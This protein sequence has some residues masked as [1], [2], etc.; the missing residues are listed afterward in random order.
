M[1][2]QASRKKTGGRDV[3]T[4]RQGSRGGRNA[5]QASRS[6]IGLDDEP[7]HPAP[8]P[9]VHG[10]N[11]GAGHSGGQ[12]VPGRLFSIPKDE[13]G[14]LF[15]IP[16]EEPGRLFN[17]PKEEPADAI[18]PIATHAASGRNVH[19]PR[20]DAGG[21][22]EPI[23]P[24]KFFNIPKEEDVEMAVLIAGPERARS[25]SVAPRLFGI[26][27]EVDSDVGTDEKVPVESAL[28][29]VRRG[30]SLFGI[31]TE[32][33]IPDMDPLVAKMLAT[34]LASRAGSSVARSES[35][36]ER[37]PAKVD[38]RAHS[39]KLFNIP[40][41]IADETATDD[42]EGSLPP[43]PPSRGT[44]EP[45]DAQK[46]QA[47]EPAGRG[48]RAASCDSDVVITGYTPAPLTHASND[49]DIEI[50]D[51]R[52]D[53]RSTSSGRHADGKALRV[54]AFPE[55]SGYQ[56]SAPPL[57][58][59]AASPGS[60]SNVLGG[61]S[62]STGEE[63]GTRKDKGKSRELPAEPDRMVPANITSTLAP[64]HEQDDAFFTFAPTAT[65][66]FN[67]APE[68]H[69]GLTGAMSSRVLELA[70]ERAAVMA[71]I[72]SLLALQRAN[73]Q[74]RAAVAWVK[75]WYR[76]ASGSR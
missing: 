9:N 16:K 72:D 24:G 63:E 66:A 65:N 64:H 27:M 34:T 18:L 4:R 48:A 12:A 32:D 71:H 14:R 36:Q 10:A 75:E 57:D 1:A 30:G 54:P 19:G 3:S 55:F 7:I 74:N 46:I 52:P 56:K 69:G 53:N 20:T 29:T 25:A 42:H 11:T 6:P 21:S 43:G 68:T 37:V 76:E 61:V 28:A 31:P 59:V 51:G 15:N 8:G 5:R 23:A 17:I 58:G 38:G 22:G 2:K 70:A 39:R 49:S 26:P 35:P 44:D 73:N 33:E 67:P 13:P 40:M 60:G 62:P 45:A 41:E 50:T 47:D